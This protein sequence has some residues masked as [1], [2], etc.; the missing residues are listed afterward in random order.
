[1]PRPA[2][3]HSVTKFKD[4][5]GPCRRSTDLDHWSKFNGFDSLQVRKM[6]P[7]VHA[8]SLHVAESGWEAPEKE[9]DNS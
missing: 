1:M 7:A 3:G 8:R 2:P 5:C 6:P 9:S 4:A